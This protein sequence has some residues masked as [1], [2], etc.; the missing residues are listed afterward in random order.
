[1]SNVA[2]WIVSFLIASVL[3]GSLLFGLFFNSLNAIL[4]LLF[5]LSVSSV[6]Y[7]I[8]MMMG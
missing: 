2:K 3:A 4:F 5:I 8:K 7:L 1:M 6:T